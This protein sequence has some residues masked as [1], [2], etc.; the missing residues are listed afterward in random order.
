MIEVLRHSI[1]VDKL[2]KKLLESEEI[3]AEVTS[4][5]TG[6]VSKLQLMEWLYILRYIIR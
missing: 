3:W 4:F 6:V 5:I 1:N 2:M